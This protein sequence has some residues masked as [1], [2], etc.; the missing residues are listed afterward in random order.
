MVQIQQENA[1]T[2]LNLVYGNNHFEL[3]DIYSKITTLFLFLL[4]T[5]TKKKRKLLIMIWI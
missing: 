2:V 3:A 4:I 5:T 1:S